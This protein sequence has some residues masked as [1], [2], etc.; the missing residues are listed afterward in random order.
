MSAVVQRMKSVSFK[1]SAM[2]RGTRRYSKASAGAVGEHCEVQHRGREVCDGVWGRGECEC[3]VCVENGEEV[4]TRKA[5]R[6]FGYDVGC[7]FLQGELV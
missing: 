3:E 1:T 4:R 7:H 6:L 5:F 2:R